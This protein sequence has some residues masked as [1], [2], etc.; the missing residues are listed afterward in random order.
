MNPYVLI[1]PTVTELES[2]RPLPPLAD[3]FVSLLLPFRN[4]LPDFLLSWHY[5]LFLLSP[6]S[7]LPIPLSALS[8]SSLLLKFPLFIIKHWD[9]RTLPSSLL[10]SSLYSVYLSHSF[11]YIYIVS[12]LFNAVWLS[13][14]SFFSSIPSFTL[15]ARIAM[16][17][18]LCIKKALGIV[19][20]LYTLLSLLPFFLIGTISLT[21]H[22]SGQFPPLSKLYY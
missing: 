7:S 12:F 5:F 2:S 9:P 14:I 11:Q 18:T 15:S 16:Y 17:N 8:F 19:S 22:S 6:P 10:L 21:F 3:T 13:G 20:L 1:M 4:L